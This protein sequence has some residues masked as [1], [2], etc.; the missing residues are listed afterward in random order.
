IRIADYGFSGVNFEGWEVCLRVRLA[1]CAR[2]KESELLQT[3]V[4]MK[5]MHRALAE[6]PELRAK[7]DCRRSSRLSS[8]PN[9]IFS[10]LGSVKEVGLP[11]IEEDLE[12]IGSIELKLRTDLIDSSEE[13]VSPPIDLSTSVQAPSEV[14]NLEVSLAP[15]LLS[16]SSADALR[17]RCPDSLACY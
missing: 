9:P 12:G 10:D 2:K 1:K 4:L 13:V 17:Q 16:P 11:S 7:V 3:R 15:E 8:Y 5:K 6:D 14:P